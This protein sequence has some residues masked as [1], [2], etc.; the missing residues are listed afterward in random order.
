MKWYKFTDSDGLPNL[1]KKKKA[2]SWLIKGN[3][4]II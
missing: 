4:E 2:K 1:K 3:A